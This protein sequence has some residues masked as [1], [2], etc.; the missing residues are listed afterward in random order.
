MML[1][2]SY[3]TSASGYLQTI[4]RVQSPCNKD[5]KTKTSCYV[6]DF[7]PDRTLKMVAEAVTI[8]TKAG[9]TTE[10]DRESLSNF[11]NYCPVISIEGTEM[12][13]YST[14]RLLQQL[15]RA[16][17]ERAV[18]N[19]FDD[20]SMY[21]DELLKLDG[22]E[23]QDFEELKGIIG[24]SKASLKTNEIDMNNQ[25][26]T[27]EEYEE[28]ER[29]E[30]KAKNERTPEEQARLDEL[31]EKKKNRKNAISI[32]RGISIRMPLLIYGAD[33]PF[34]EEITIDK[35]AD[36]VDEQSW[37]E[38]MPDGVTKEIFNK[39]SK[40]YDTDV[41]VSA[42]RRIRNVAKA[43]DE[44]EPL[45]RTKKIAQ[46]FSCFKNPDKETVLTPWRVVNMHMSDCI[47]GYKFYD[48]ENKYPIETPKEIDRGRVTD[49]VLKNPNTKVLEIN[50]KTGLYPLYVAYSIYANKCKS[51]DKSELT[52]EK[53]Q[54]IWDETI[55]DNIFV[56]CKTPM[57][58][59]ITKRT[60]VG[61]RSIK[62]NAHYFEDLINMLQNKPEQFRDKVL[63]KSYW[64][65][66][67]SGQMKFDAIV[68]NPPYQIM[69]GGGDGNSAQPIYNL[70]VDEAKTLEPKYISMIMPARWYSGGKGLDK[71]R[72]EMLTDKRLN[73]I[74]DFPET[75]DVF[76]GVNIRGGICYFLWNNK[77]E[78]DCNVY[79]HFKGNINYEKR[80]LLE[81]NAETFIR[82]NRAITIL[83][84][85]QKFNE[86][87]FDNRVSSRLPF[88]IES[89]FKDY[90]NEK[91]GEYTIALYRS[92]RGSNSKTNKKVYIKED[93][94]KKNEEWKDR[95]KVLV[96]KASPG[97]DEYPHQIISEPIIADKNSVCTETYLIV[98]FV[99]TIEQGENLKRYMKTK[100]FR[101]LISLI[102]NTQN[103]S[104]SCFSFVPV[105]DNNQEWTDEKLYK[106]YNLDKEEIE[107]IDSMIKPMN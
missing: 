93:A 82:Y 99:D 80:P 57:A 6:F 15:K 69:D 38:F 104:K 7:A 8:S 59:Q 52:S 45:E 46:L 12:K 54:Q 26:F 37:K 100:F 29:L 81:K 35:F 64:E 27:N 86:E 32:L 56:I 87:T 65:Q 88:G 33:V 60:L 11:L 92:D 28:K 48:D 30:K 106:K 4:F 67:G 73:T 101:F 25:G 95:I 22:V 97:G 70:F 68:G 10:S 85:V 40:Y 21:N 9:R 34:N 76:G 53:K 14:N 84:K 16:Y 83:R 19:G 63:R 105:Q 13:Q 77:T 91:E 66:E 94:I 50:S 96:S 61:Y 78:E 71:F 55:K 42:G 17:A 75:Q 102:K 72:M 1:S 39:F 5:G 90:K 24:S 23:L 98:D 20:V 31:N 79:N 62:V 51:Y 3:S 47:G 41:F 36:L 58:K 107:F 2:G 103:I 89:N 18:L 74:H 49:E 43:S 44:L